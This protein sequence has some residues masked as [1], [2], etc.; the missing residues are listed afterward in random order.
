MPI[1]SVHLLRL[2]K[3][4]FS[5]IAARLLSI[6]H[7]TGVRARRPLVDDKRGEVAAKVIRLLVAKIIDQLT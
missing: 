2:N 5:F 1:I 3:S 6:C 4:L 7:S